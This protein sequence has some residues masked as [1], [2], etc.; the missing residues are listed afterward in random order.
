VQNTEADQKN[1]ISEYLH[2]G[3]KLLLK[4]DIIVSERK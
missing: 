3:M 1:V 4:R 2:P